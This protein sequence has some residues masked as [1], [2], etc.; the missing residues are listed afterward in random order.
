[1]DDNIK[2][3]LDGQIKVDI[4]N[5]CLLDVG[6]EQK[7]KEVEN[8][9]KLYQLRIDEDKN[10]RESKD[11]R[12]KSITDIVRTG[13]EIG[14]GLANLAFVGYWMRKT[15]IFEE[16]GSITSATGRNMLNKVFKLTK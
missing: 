1:M 6:S 16:T 4:E 8:L 7:A 14:L 11:A 3:L 12:K 13:A 2:K 10:E 5:L 9:V 15:F